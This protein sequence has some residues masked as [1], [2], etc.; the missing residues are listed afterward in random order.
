[1]KHLFDKGV[2]KIIASDVDPAGKADHIRAMFKD[3]DFELLVVGK[4]DFSI[5]YKE[6]DACCPCAVGEYLCIYFRRN[7]ESKYHSKNKSI[8]YCWGG[9]QPIKRYQ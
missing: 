8:D 4:D 7:F 6:A 5:L 3:Y 9:K 2:R 1:M